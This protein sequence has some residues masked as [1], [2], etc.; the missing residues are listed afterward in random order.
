MT[1]NRVFI[2]YSHNDEDQAFL[3]EFRVHLKPW[4]K[5]TQQD[6]WSDHRIPPGQDW[7]QEIQDEIQLVHP[8][9]VYS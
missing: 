7:H 8:E 4:E 3:E 6:I 1:R 2:S 9:N 5:T